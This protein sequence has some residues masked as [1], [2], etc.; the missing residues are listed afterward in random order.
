MFRKSP[1]KSPAR[2]YEV[3]N[4]KYIQQ[5]SDYEELRAELNSLKSK[6]ATATSELEDAKE[7]SKKK[8][9][10]AEKRESDMR[11]KYKD[12]IEAMQATAVRRENEMKR[13]REDLQ[14]Y[15]K[16]KSKYPLDSHFSHILGIQSVRIFI[17][18]P[19]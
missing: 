13:L 6:Y 17:A 10:L 4:Q 8:I 19:T 5:T 15:E 9:K 11:R 1:K 7:Q 16:A 18:N 14:R 3:L 12:E 2:D